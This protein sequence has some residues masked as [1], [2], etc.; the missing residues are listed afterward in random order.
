MKEAA[1][2][3]G[4]APGSEP[5]MEVAERHR[6]HISRW[7]YDCSPAAHRNLGQMY[8]GDERFAANYESVAPGLAAYMCDAIAA[9]SARASS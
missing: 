2:A 4:E 9:N 6:E 7:F 3:A 5:A 8:A 1:H